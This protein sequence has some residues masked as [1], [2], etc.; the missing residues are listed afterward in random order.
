MPLAEA[1]TMVQRLEISKKRCERIG[2]LAFFTA[3]LCLTMGTVFVLA[4]LSQ[5]LR[6]F[7]SQRVRRPTR[8]FDYLYRKEHVSPKPLPQN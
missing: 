1:E 5:P 7:Q 2:R 8:I 6:S 3:A 4:D